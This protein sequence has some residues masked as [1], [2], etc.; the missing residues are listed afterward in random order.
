L[1]PPGVAA[2]LAVDAPGLGPLALSAHPYLQIAWA[3]DVE[4]VERLKMRLGAGE[5]EA[6][7]LA[8]E[9]RAD[10]VL[11]DETDARAAASTLGL[12][13]RGVLATLVEAK[14]AGIVARVAPLIDRLEDRI[15]FRVSRE[16][17]AL[18]L[19]SARE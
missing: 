9:T 1:I 15:R 11:L 4:L 12:R 10:L 17:R 3:K 16:V 19:K 8:V 14:R 6:L 18:V 2:E 5:S 13:T 7:A